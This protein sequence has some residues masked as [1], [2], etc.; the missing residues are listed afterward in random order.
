MKMLGYLI[1]HWIAFFLFGISYVTSKTCGQ[2]PCGDT[3]AKFC[4]DENMARIESGHCC[5]NYDGTSSSVECQS[6]SGGFPWW[7]VFLIVL[8]II[9]VLVAVGI[10]VYRKK[11]YSRFF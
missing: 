2:T 4:C 1:Y 7:G 10:V 5:C 3:Y 6:S 9:A 8:F 11:L